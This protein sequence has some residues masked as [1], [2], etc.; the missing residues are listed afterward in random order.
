MPTV[1]LVFP[2]WGRNYFVWAMMS[3][4]FEVFIN[5]IIIYELSGL[6]LSGHFLNSI[7]QNELP[8]S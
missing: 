8:L 2:E 5:K 4:K 1:G 7:M 6:Q 3:T